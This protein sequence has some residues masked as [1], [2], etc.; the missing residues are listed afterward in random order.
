M[1]TILVVEASLDIMDREAEYN[2]ID[3]EVLNALK[4]TIFGK[5][6]TECVSS[7]GDASRYGPG[8]HFFIGRH[9]VFSEAH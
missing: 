2:H 6:R 3:G 1:S 9:A 5:T 8:E 7:C 4:K